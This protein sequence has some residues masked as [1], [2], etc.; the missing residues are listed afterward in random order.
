M[1]RLAVCGAAG[2]MGSRIISLAKLDNQLKV[3]LA[4]E[5]KDHPKLSIQIEGL[6][7]TDD[8]SKLAKV[9]CVVDFTQPQATLQHLS[10]CILYKRPIVIGTTGFSDIEI[11]TIIKASKSIPILLSPNMSIGVNLVFKLVKDLASLL[12]DYKIRIIEK[13][14]IHKKDAPSGTA[15]QIAKIINEISGKKIED[16][17]SIREGD[18]VGDHEIIFDSQF[19]TIWLKHC[20]KSRDIFAQGALAAAKWLVNKKS[21]MYSMQDCLFTK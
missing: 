5:Q 18:I 10:K 15:K 17:Q 16:I 8:E 19:D 20:A 12:K 7:I 1:I 6:T 2:R 21:G 13:H 9:D 3:D 4:L 11:K 14:H